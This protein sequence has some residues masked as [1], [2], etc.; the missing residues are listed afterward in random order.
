MIHPTAEISISATIGENTKIW[1]LAQIREH[2]II[3]SNC[4]L[5]K[6]VYIDKDVKVGSQCKIQNNSSLYCGVIVEDQVFIGPHCVLMNDKIPRATTVQGALKIDTDWQVEKTI[7]K[8][9]ASLGAHVAVLPGITIGNYAL[10]GTGSVVTKNIPDYSLAYG[11]PARVVG[12]VCQ[13]GNKL[14]KWQKAGEE[15]TNC[16]TGNNYHR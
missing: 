4:I 5:G 8:K 9:G 3:G 10:I 14:E 12:F 16:E 7:V 6:N 13:C 11:S 1:H 15:C 2:A